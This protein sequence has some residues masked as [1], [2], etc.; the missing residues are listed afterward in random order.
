MN[1]Y[2]HSTANGAQIHFMCLSI[3]SCSVFDRRKHYF[4]VSF[5]L[6]GVVTLC[7]INRLT[8]ME[9]VSSW[10]TVTDETGAMSCG[11]SPVTVDA[12]DRSFVLTQKLASVS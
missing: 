3:Y 4:L 6:V 12:N 8:G 9:Q 10:K 2:K 5:A 11:N 7:A 1:L